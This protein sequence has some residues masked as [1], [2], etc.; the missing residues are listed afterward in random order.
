M[1]SIGKP[2]RL[3][4]LQDVACDTCHLNTL[5]LP[6]DLASEKVTELKEIIQPLAR[7]ARHEV[8]YYQ[9]AELDNLYTVRSG[10]LKQVTTTETGEYLVTA[11]FLPGELIGLDAIADEHYPGS[12]V[13]LETSSVCALPFKP[14]EAL[15]AQRLELCLRLHRSLSQEIHNERLRL[16]LL[17]RRTAEGRVACFLTALSERFQ[18]RGYSPYRFHLSLSR[19]DLGSYLGLTEE[20]V[21]RAL[22]RCQEQG[23]VTVRGREIRILDMPNLA[24][25]AHASGRRK[26]QG[27]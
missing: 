5:C 12:V 21:G 27:G 10:S 26:A 6:G 8:L 7:L 24:R 16:R 11:L 4:S 14:L 3:A 19:A 17:L 13:A 15:C 22:M 1:T 23:L 9:G 18:R 2:L 20:T 25:L